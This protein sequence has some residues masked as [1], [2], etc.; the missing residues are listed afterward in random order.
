MIFLVILATAV[1]VSIVLPTSGQGWHS[2]WRGKVIGPVLRL[3]A[4]PARGIIVRL[5][6]PRRAHQPDPFEAL[7]VQ[8][9][10]SALAEEIQA[11]HFDDAAFARAARLEARSDAYDALLREACALAGVENLEEAPGRATMRMRRELELA[12]RGW[13]W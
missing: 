3:V 10:L 9:R 1:V 4:R 5:P 11:L 2:G 7:R 8:N 6:L 12:Q 13:S